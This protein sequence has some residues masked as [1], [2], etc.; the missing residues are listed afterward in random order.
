MHLR[1]NSSG[2]PG[3]SF[4]CGV[5]R[6]QLCVL[7]HQRRPRKIVRD[8][9][10]GTRQGQLHGYSILVPRHILRMNRDPNSRFGAPISRKIRE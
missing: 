2:L 5:L 10:G 3:L 9:P 8:G 1:R 7:F 6:R 4:L